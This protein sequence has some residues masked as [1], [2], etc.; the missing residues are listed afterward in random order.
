MSFDAF[1]F[2]LGW[3]GCCVFIGLAEWLCA[4]REQ[5]HS[6]PMTEAHGDCPWPTKEER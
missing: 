4:I 2:I 3:A 6:D 1:S 5:H